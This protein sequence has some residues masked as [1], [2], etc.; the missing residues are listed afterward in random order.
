MPRKPREFEYYPEH[1]KAWAPFGPVRGVVGWIVDGD[2]LDAM[3]DLGRYQYAYVSLRLEDVWSR[4]GEAEDIAAMRYVERLAPIG[5]PIVV[6]TKVGPLS[7]KEV[8][9]FERFVSRVRLPDGSWLNERINAF[10][11]DYRRG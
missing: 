4:D 10:L 5:T 8:M 11:E 6:H 1:M 2:T 3:L 9:T 7:G